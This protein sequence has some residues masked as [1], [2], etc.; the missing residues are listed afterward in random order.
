MLYFIFN[1]VECDVRLFG[2]FFLL[3]FRRGPDFEGLFANSDAAEEEAKREQCAHEQKDRDHAGEVD[4][5]A[6]LPV[7]AEIVIDFVLVEDRLQFQVLTHE[8][9]PVREGVNLDCLSGVCT[10]VLVEE[11]RQFVEAAAQVAIQ[12]EVE[13]LVVAFEGHEAGGGRA[14]YGSEPG[15]HVIVE[16]EVV[17]GVVSR[18]LVGKDE[19]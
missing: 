7:E 4:T 1:V 15:L 10:G 6:W 14:Q 11:L 3:Y 8:V 2:D 13:D 9:D 18:E 5:P 12:N 19:V 17:G 16:M